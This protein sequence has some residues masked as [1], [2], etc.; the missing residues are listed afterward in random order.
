LEQRRLEVK[1]KRL[2]MGWTEAEDSVL[3][4][5][6]SAPLVHKL[7]AH[8]KTEFGNYPVP[9]KD[10]LSTLGVVRQVIAT[11]VSAAQ[12]IEWMGWYFDA[13]EK[14]DNLFYGR[15]NAYYSL[16]GFLTKILWIKQ[17]G[18]TAYWLRGRVSVGTLNDVADM[19]LI[20]YQ[21]IISP[22]AEFGGDDLAAVG[23]ITGFVERMAPVAKIST[24]KLIEYVWRVVKI[25]CENQGTA[26]YIRAATAWAFWSVAMP[27]YLDQVLPN[28]INR[29]Q[30][31]KELRK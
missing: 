15:D 11:G 7:K 16:R 29:E 8:R 20:K 22:G 30:W 17:K 21:D 1:G 2:D 26:P 9:E 4:A 14:G 23:R 6:N 13:C 28:E 18:G 12:I 31:N 25:E 19:L 24:D 10:R 5:W 27:N 3:R